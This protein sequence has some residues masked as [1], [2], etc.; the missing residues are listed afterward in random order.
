MGI[1]HSNWSTIPGRF[2]DYISTPKINN[3]KS[4]HTALIGPNNERVEIQRFPFASSTPSSDIGESS[5]TNAYG[6]QRGAST[7]TH[8]HTAHRY[9][10]GGNGIDRFAFGSSTSGAEI[11]EVANLQDNEG[12]ICV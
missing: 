11:G 3:Y 8:G 12:M 6:S 2:K 9:G 10:P 1:F 7:L 5:A 4:I